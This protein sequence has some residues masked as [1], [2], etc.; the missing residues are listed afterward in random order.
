MAGSTCGPIGAMLTSPV[1]ETVVTIPSRIINIP[2][3]V[4]AKAHSKHLGAPLRALRLCA[5]L[6][7]AQRPQESLR[8]VPC[9]LVLAFRHRFGDD[10]SA[11]RELQPTSAC[12][13][14]AD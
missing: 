14:R 13:K 8:L 7:S 12:G 1:G 3:A 10:T 5:R 2:N 4:R 11:D 6:L 9:L